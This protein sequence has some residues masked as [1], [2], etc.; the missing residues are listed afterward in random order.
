VQPAVAYAGNRG[1]IDLDISPTA[2][3]TTN[4]S[5]A[6]V[7][8]GDTTMDPDADLFIA[9]TQLRDGLNTFDR[10]LIKQG[11]DNIREI[12]NRING[13]L[14]TVGCRHLS[15]ENTGTNLEDFNESLISLQNTY[16]GVDYPYTITQFVA[17][18]SSQEAA[19]SIL[20]KMGRMNLFD[21]IG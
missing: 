21:Y 11:Y 4:L 6:Y 17:E 13:C 3:V 15:I 18:Q 19:L 20:A 7:F 5:G 10:D 8:Q 16:D 2:T 14:V 1:N 9:V 12:K